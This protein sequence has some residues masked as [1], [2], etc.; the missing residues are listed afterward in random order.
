MA[1]YPLLHL[2]EGFYP[3]IIRVGNHVLYEHPDVVMA[4]M[5]NLIVVR[6]EFM[7]MAYEF[8]YETISKFFDPVEEGAVT[9]EY[10]VVVQDDG[11]IS[12][13]KQY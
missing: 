5:A 11:T 6:C 8:R 7:F 13:V 3:G 10:D 1:S 12:F 4:I 9:P 2:P